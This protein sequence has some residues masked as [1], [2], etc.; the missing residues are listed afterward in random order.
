MA[1]FIQTLLARLWHEDEG[2]LTF[3]YIMLNTAL[4]LG[5]VGA[6]NGIRDS[7]N[8]EA[9]SLSQSILSLDQMRPA[10]PTAPGSN[11][12]A[13]SN[14]AGQSGSLIPLTGTASNATTANA[15]GS[16]GT[17]HGRSHR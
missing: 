8:A 2:L 13:S 10:M 5:T 7:I 4:V 12:T 14:G 9:T 17:H 3:E 11:Q 1:R 16:S 6:V 15:T